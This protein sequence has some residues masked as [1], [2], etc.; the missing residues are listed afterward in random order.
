MTAT[1]NDAILMVELAQWGSMAG[2]DEAARDVMSDQFDPEQADIQDA[3]VSK[4]LMFGE[5]IGTLVKNGLLDRQLV[6]DWLWV[7]GS[8]AKV[9]PAARR[10]R[11]KA[12]VPKLYENYEA[13]AAG[14]KLKSAT[15]RFR[16]R[17]DA[18]RRARTARRTAS[19]RT[20]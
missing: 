11:E 4:V 9:A 5:T 7:E 3:S 6:Y 16:Q 19:P 18:G 17:P 20:P 2:I 15:P 1:H 12:G 13:L 8:W 14:Q 10:A